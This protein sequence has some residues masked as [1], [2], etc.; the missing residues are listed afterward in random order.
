MDKTVFFTEVCQCVFLCLGLVCAALA[1]F[2]HL[3]DRDHANE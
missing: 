3:A 1:L 2:T